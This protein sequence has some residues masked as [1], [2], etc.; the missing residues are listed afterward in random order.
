MDLYNLIQNADN[1][2]FTWGSNSWINSSYCGENSRILI[3][4][5]T[6]YSNE[7]IN[8]AANWLPHTYKKLLFFKDIISNHEICE[9]NRKI[10]G[11]KMDELDKTD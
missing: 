2:I 6:D 3:L 11:E 7:Y 1:L 4:C 9:T 10:L 8:Q 5:S